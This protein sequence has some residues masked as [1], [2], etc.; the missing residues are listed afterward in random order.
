MVHAGVIGVKG[1]AP[2]KLTWRLPKLMEAAMRRAGT[3]PRKLEL[4]PRED[5]FSLAEPTLA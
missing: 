3:L 2:D 1:T 5:E 4:G